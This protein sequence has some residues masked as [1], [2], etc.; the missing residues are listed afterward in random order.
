M[1][2]TGPRI[3]TLDVTVYRVP[4]DAPE[5][6]GTLAWDAT[7]MIVVETEADG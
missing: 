1:T 4:T 6:D 7:T 5:S 2:S 3:E